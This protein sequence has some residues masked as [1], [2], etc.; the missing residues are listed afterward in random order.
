MLSYELDIFKAYHKNW[1]LLTAGSPD[2]F[3]TMTI[4]WG[5]LGTFWNK[6]V[7]TVYVR[8]NR[9]TFS[10]MEK[11]EYFTVSFF[12]DSYRK[13]LTVLGT[14]SG[15]DTNKIAQTALTPIRA[16]GSMTFQ[17]ASVTLICKKMLA[18]DF[19][20]DQIPEQIMQSMYAIDPVHRMYMG[21]VIEILRNK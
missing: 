1:A 7:A 11:N 2:D 3:N 4:S 18:Q 19:D 6:S 8:P 9:H 10:Y 14:L 13:D 5:G 12:D 21:E 16:G 15:R 20:L 17:Q